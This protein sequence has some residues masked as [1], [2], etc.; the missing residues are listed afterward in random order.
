MFQI[1]WGFYHHL[2]DINTIFSCQRCIE[3]LFRLVRNFASMS[4]TSLHPLSDGLSELLEN[5]LNKAFGSNYKPMSKIVHQSIRKNFKGFTGKIRESD[6]N[7]IFSS[8]ILNL[9]LIND[10]TKGVLSMKRTHPYSFDTD[11]ALRVLKHLKYDIE[12]HVSIISLSY[13]TNASIGFEILARFF[14]AKLLHCPNDRTRNVVKPDIFLQPTPK[15]IAIVKKFIDKNGVKFK[16]LPRILVSN[17]NTMELFSFERNHSNDKI[18][19]SDTLMKVLFMTML[20]PKPNIW[21]PKNTPERLWIKLDINLI[22]EGSDYLQT[23]NKLETKTIVSPLFHKYFTN[24]ESDSHVQYYCSNTGLRVFHNKVINGVKYSYCV[25]GKAVVQWLMDCTDCWDLKTAMEIGS[26]FVKLNLLISINDGNTFESSHDTFYT[27]SKTKTVWASHKSSKS[28]GKSKVQ[29]PI[30]Q[31]PDLQQF[32]GDPGLQY[33]FKIH[34]ENEYCGENID[35]Y[36]EL[37]LFSKK[38]KLLTKL[39]EY[40]DT[41]HHSKYKRHVIKL[42]NDCLSLAYHIYFTYLSVEAPFILNIDY[43]LRNRISALL[44]DNDKSVHVYD[45]KT[46]MEIAP[47][48]LSVEPLEDSV[49]GHEICSKAS[50]EETATPKNDTFKESTSEDNTIYSSISSPEQLGCNNIESQI[51]DNDV[52]SIFS[53]S[54]SCLSPQSETFQQ[55]YDS[56]MCFAPLANELMIN[57]Y[58]LM[59]VDSFPKFLESNVFESYV[60]IIYD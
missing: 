40:I 42:S 10:T 3:K 56:L 23:A 57:I 47:K 21:S 12:S 34:L 2:N 44:I 26:V 6:L 41:K 27:I 28:K 35:A 11:T 49:T 19:Y 54:Q 14:S 7:D 22:Y 4:Q 30:S 1:Q 18:I 31:S 25:S 20:G 38:M 16:R 48:P 53:S 55:T 17:L 13:Q 37:K 45:L 33:I 36:N 52:D 59:Q 51:I 9:N 39:I 29:L 58:R 5:P 43:N 60:D 8:M 46:P 15:G 32:L 50:T 24:P